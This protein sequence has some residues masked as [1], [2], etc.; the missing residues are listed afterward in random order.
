MGVTAFWKLLVG[1][2]ER[3]AAGAGAPG[4]RPVAGSRRRWPGSIA[5]GV[6]MLALT[7]G[8]SLSGVLSESDFQKVETIK[9]LLPRR[10]YFMRFSPTK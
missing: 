4:V 7:P 3:V 6:A 2:A 9:P 5:F 10:L 1:S 8:V